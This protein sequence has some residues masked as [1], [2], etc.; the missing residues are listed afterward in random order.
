MSKEETVSLLTSRGVGLKN[1]IPL[2]FRAEDLE[3]A[4]VMKGGG[5]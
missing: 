3:E 5:E 4:A 2:S 1:N